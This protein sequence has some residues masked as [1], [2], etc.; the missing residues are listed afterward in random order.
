MNHIL[1]PRFEDQTKQILGVST[2]H[3]LLVVVFQTKIT[4][5]NTKQENQANYKHHRRRNDIPRE[6]AKTY[7]EQSNDEIVFLLMIR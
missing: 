6:V 5:A 2:D 3:P 7:P 1:A 4:A